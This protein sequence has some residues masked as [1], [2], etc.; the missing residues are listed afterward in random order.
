MAN[1]DACQFAIEVARLA[2]DSK[3]ED[4]VA[5]DLRGISPVTDFVVICTGTSDRQ[6][7]AVADAV[8]EYGKKVGER[9]YG[10][11]GYDNA[12][13]ILLDFVT[14]I[15]HVFSRTHRAYYDLELLWGDAPQLEWARSESA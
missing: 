3:S 1:Q 9:P 15:L 2:H 11:A 12:V 10:L 13:W 14:V 4:V 7:R 8:R 6:M 5:L